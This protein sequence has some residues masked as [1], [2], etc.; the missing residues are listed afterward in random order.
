M[1]PTTRQ[2]VD[3]PTRIIRAAADPQP[4]KEDELVV[5]Q[6]DLDSGRRMA[7]A[8]RQRR[9]E[10]ILDL[11]RNHGYPPVR[12]RDVLNAAGANLTADAIEKVLKRA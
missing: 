12:I 3:P 4:S 10:L 7:E 8:A 1:A 5:A 9:N 6:V 11:N 2:R